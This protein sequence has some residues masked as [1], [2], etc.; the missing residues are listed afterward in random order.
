MPHLSEFVVAEQ[1]MAS[2][3]ASIPQHPQDFTSNSAGAGER[4]FEHA[5][6]THLLLWVSTHYSEGVPIRR[7]RGGDWV[8]CC[9]LGCR[10]HGARSRNRG[11]A[12]EMHSR[13]NTALAIGADMAGLQEMTTWVIPL[14]L[15]VNRG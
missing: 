13:L 10:V 8:G 5:V 9:G 4:F 14:P 6:F 3:L 12:I 15:P 11:A 1:A 7:K 2:R